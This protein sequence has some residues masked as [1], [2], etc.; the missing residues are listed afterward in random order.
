MDH[1]AGTPSDLFPPDDADLA[2]DLLLILETDE[3][4]RPTQSSIRV[5]SK[6]LSPASPMFAGMLSAKFGRGSSS[7]RRDFT[8]YSVNLPSQRQLRSHD[9]T[10]QGSSSF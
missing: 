9:L 6:V 4:G 5:S 1:S 3:D 8:A 10:V 2:G 7:R